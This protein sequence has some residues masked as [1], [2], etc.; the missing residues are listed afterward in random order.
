VPG[1]PSA[2]WEMADSYGALGLAFENIGHGF[3]GIDD[4]GW[5]GAA[6]DAFHACLERQPKRFLQASDAFVAAAGALDD[7]AST[8]SWAQGQAAEAIALYR[9]DRAV[10]ERAAALSVGEQA[11]LTGVVAA[12]GDEPVVR[13]SPGESALAACDT[14]TRARVQVRQ[15]GFEAAAVVR[16]AGELAAHPAIREPVVAAGR[17]V[18]RARPLVISTVRDVDL[19]ARQSGVG[20]GQRLDHDTL[21]DSP[22]AWE[23]GVAELRKVLRL[24]L[25]Q[26][27]P[28]LRTHIFEGHFKKRKLGNGYRDVGYHHREGGIDRGEVRVVRIV[29]SPDGNGVYRARIAGGKTAGSSEFRTST[30]FPDA[31][32]RAEVLRAV[33]LA[34]L[35]R[36][37]DVTDPT[38]ARRW[39]GR[40]CGM[41]I[42]GYVESQCTQLPVNAA[43]A[44]LYHIVTA[45]PIYRSGDDPGD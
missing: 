17:A 35:R 9:D 28:R 19:L 36:T 32:S 4:G 44:R 29:A 37:F 26:L 21:R 45:Y 12:V 22:L 13:A 15:A 23:A 38:A 25:D 2:V 20:L 42:E 18:V 24:G 1:N 43:S 39:R 8:L 16:E 30:F 7:Y 14:L 6:A 3:R 40:A 11:R 31:W 33:R 41:D 10:V 34:F 27:S 5:R